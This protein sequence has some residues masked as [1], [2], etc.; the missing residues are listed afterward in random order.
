LLKPIPV[1]DNSAEIV[2]SSHTVE[3][4]ADAAALNLFKEAQRILKRDGVL[5]MTCP[6]VDLAYRAYREGD[7]GYFCRDSKDWRTLGLLQPFSDISLGQLF[8]LSFASVASTAHVADT[9]K[10]GD[11]ELYDLFKNLG[12]KGALN[13]CISKCSVELQRKFPGAHINWWNPRK[14]VRMLETAN[15]RKILVSAYGQSFVHVLRNTRFFDNTAP[16]IS[17]YVEATK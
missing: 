14:L 9:E 2:Y 16:N 11:V 3:H 10:I 15:F 5:R 6:N 7:Y 13:F 4:I 8:L 12:F 1:E 17:L